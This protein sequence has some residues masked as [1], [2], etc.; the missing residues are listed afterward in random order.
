[1][2]TLASHDHDKNVKAMEAACQGERKVWRRSVFHRRVLFRAINSV[3]A[4]QGSLK[5]ILGYG[6]AITHRT[7]EPRVSDKAFDTS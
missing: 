7:L 1:M 6:W 4:Y 2:S 3:S 5:M